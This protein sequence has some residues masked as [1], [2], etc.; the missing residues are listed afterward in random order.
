MISSSCLTRLHGLLVRSSRSGIPARPSPASPAGCGRRSG[1]PVKVC[2]F[3][4]EWKSKS[5]LQACHHPVGVLRRSPGNHGRR[6][7]SRSGGNE[8]LMFEGHLFRRELGDERVVVDGAQ[9]LV[10]HGTARAVEGDGVLHDELMLVA[11]R[12]RWRR[13]GAHFPGGCRSVR[14]LSARP[15]GRLPKG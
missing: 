14:C 15:G 6:W 12:I 1:V 3:F 4:T 7:Q 8:I 13:G 10:E 9:V 2:L 11:V 5:M